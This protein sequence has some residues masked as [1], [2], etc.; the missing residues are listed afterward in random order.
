MPA[1]IVIADDN[2]N[3]RTVVKMDL[4]T[5]GYQVLEATDGL[6]ALELVK[7]M[8][9]DLVVLD[10]MMPGLDG[11]DVCSRIKMDEELRGIPVI[12]LTAKTTPEDKF[13]GRKVGAD[14]YLT[15]P[16]D[17]EDLEKLIERI[18]EARSKGE[19]LHPLTGL[20]LWQ[21]VEHEIT[22]RKGHRRP[23]VVMN[24]FFEEEPF[25]V[26]QKKYGAIWADAALKTA[27]ETIKSITNAIP[28]FF[29]GQSGDN[30]FFFIGSPEDMENVKVSLTQA[31]A[32][33]IPT[34]YDA[35]DR[36]A[37]YIYLK[38]PDGKGKKINLM[39]WIWRLNDAG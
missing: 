16:F 36:E 27:A 35:A 21:A 8:K 28:G 26:F 19:A 24:G 34:F 1:T 30:V 14:E 25:N 7:T 38:L 18:L 37:G 9:P 6:Q 11:F 3:I 10:V 17:P 32:E 20:P 22:R 12:M 33:T 5:L 15:K 39:K 31:M 4:E 13:L 29:L 23:F 2:R